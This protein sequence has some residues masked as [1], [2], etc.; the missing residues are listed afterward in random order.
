M[1]DFEE[2][3]C[4][5]NELHNKEDSLCDT[6]GFKERDVW[7]VSLGKNIG[8]EEDGKNI[9][10]ERPVVVIR[11]FSNKLFL[12]VPLTSKDRSESNFVNFYHK[13]ENIN[14]L[15]KETGKI[16]SIESISTAIIPQVRTI[17]S[18]RL[19]RKYG[20][21]SEDDFK[22]ICRKIKF[23]LPRKNPAD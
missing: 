22:M 1:E 21:V 17:S 11:R 3:H 5:K 12:A 15:N 16:E 13:I 14:K 9:N 10:Y 2:W 23:L 4:L 20:M 19:I 8:W 7:W 18:K 6:Y